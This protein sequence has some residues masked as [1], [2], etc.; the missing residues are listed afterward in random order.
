MNSHRN[1]F[2]ILFF[3]HRSKKNKHSEHPIYCRLTVQGKSR[4]FSTQIWSSND[5]WNPS[6]SRIIGSKESAQTANHT[7]GTIFTSLMNIRNNLMSEGKLI[8]AENVINIHLG[9]TGNKYTLIE[10]HEYHNENHVKKLIGKDCKRP[11]FP[12]SSKLE[13]SKFISSFQIFYPLNGS[14]QF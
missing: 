5:N 2:S 11:L 14:F 13:F 7:L 12:V 4:E 3:M 10:I 9:K 8:S 6:S 1:T